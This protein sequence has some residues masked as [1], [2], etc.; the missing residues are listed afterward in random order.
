[1]FPT[2]LL[3]ASWSACPPVGCTGVNL[4]TVPF[5][6]IGGMGALI[7]PHSCCESGE[8]KDPVALIRDA[9]RTFGETPDRSNRDPIV[10][11]E[12]GK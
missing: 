8:G 1:L 5:V 7:D 6:L 11:D 12:P 2:L 9:V 4:M 3:Q 10:L